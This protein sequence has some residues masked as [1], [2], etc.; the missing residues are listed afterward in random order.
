MLEDWEAYQE[1]L[2]DYSR[3]Y[4]KITVGAGIRGVVMMEIYIWAWGIENNL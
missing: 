2:C 1:S 3:A 4:P